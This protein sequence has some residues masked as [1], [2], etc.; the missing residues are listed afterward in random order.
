MLR[1]VLGSAA[2]LGI[3]RL[4]LVNAGRVEKSYW[5][6]P[7][8]QAPALRECLV[9]GLEQACDTLLP[10]IS[11]HPR[12]R[13]FVEDEL[14]AIASGCE[15]LLAHPAASNVARLPHGKRVA[16]AVGA[17]GGFTDFEIGLFGSVGFAAFTL[18]A[19]ILRVETALPALAATLFP[20]Q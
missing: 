7:L 9:A 8:L 6:S 15:K 2:E 4:C 16:L 20:A 19:R 5:Q 12:L 10:E 1:R 11:L 13:P 3:K 18:G 14:P 17:E